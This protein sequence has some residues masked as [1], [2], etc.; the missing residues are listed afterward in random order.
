MPSATA[1]SNGVE[2]SLILG[3]ADWALKKRDLKKYKK[4]FYSAIFQKAIQ[5]KTSVCGF[6][7]IEDN[8][9]SRLIFGYNS[10]AEEANAK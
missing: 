7:P 8:D 10:S 9:Q 2:E 5:P 1:I 3:A 4:P 6:I